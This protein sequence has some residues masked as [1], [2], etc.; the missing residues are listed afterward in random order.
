MVYAGCSVINHITTVKSVFLRRMYIHQLFMFYHLLI[1]DAT[2][3]QHPF[4]HKGSS[5]FRS[6]LQHSFWTPY[7]H[8]RIV[9]C[10][11]YCWT[12]LLLVMGCH[13]RRPFFFSS[14]LPI[15]TA[16]HIFPLCFTLNLGNWRTR[17]AHHNWHTGTPGFALEGGDLWEPEGPN[18]NHHFPH[19]F[20]H[21]QQFFFSRTNF[22][23]NRIFS[24]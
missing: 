23:E 12:W 10:W 7:C 14:P 24:F 16:D 22:V 2:Q 20:F 13:H 11:F 6:M 18:F 8:P 5:V 21:I 19:L 15:H 17:A 9:G 4:L 3:L 1:V